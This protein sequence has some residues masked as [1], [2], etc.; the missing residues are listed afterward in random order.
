MCG[1]F[2]SDLPSR[3]SSNKYLQAAPK[4]QNI[5]INLSRFYNKALSYT[6]SQSEAIWFCDGVLLLQLLKWASLISCKYFF[7]SFSL[8]FIITLIP[9]HTPIS[10]VK[11]L[12]SLKPI[13]YKYGIT[14]Q[15]HL[16]IWPASFLN[17]VHMY[18]HTYNAQMNNS[19]YKRTIWINSFKK[20]HLFNVVAY[21]WLEESLNLTWLHQ[22]WWI[23]RLIGS[24]FLLA[25]FGLSQ[26]SK[27]S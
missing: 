24:K 3:F 6:W 8:N 20:W 21:L 9:F 16:N 14:T 7:V 10:H 27:I 18:I 11:H 26:I 12:S 17:I 13:S 19:C 2:P 23:V 25:L 15:I 4:S 22:N 1:F 5:S